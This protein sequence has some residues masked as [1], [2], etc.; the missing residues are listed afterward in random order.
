[1]ARLARVVAVGFPHHI[2]QRGN[3]PQFILTCDEER[4]VYMELLRQATQL[5]LLTVLGYCLMSNHVHLVAFPEKADSLAR[6]MKE[7]HGRYATYWNAAQGRSGHAWQGRFYSCPLDEVHLW[8]ALRYTELNPV[9]AGMVQHAEL[10][11]WSSAAA[12]CGT[13]AGD[14]CLAM[15]RWR[16]AWTAS[17][18]KEFLAVGETEEQLQGLRQCTHTGRPLG[19]EAFIQTLEQSTQRMLAPRRGGRPARD[20]IDDKQRLITFDT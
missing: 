1:M 20:S 9:R 15:D 7:T 3:A 4:A 18:W 13:V 10:W 6:A 11:K 2:T 17:R 14:S 19:S 8:E 5:H 16:Q 12:H